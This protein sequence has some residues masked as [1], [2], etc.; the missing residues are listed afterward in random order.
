MQIR[1]S[2]KVHAPVLSLLWTALFLFFLLPLPKASATDFS[3]TNFKV[4]DPVFQAA[5]TTLTSSTNFRLLGTAGEIAIGTSSAT[6]FKVSSGFLYYPEVI[7]LPSV[8]ATAGDKSVDLSWTPASAVLGWKVSGYN[9]GYATVSDGPY[10]YGSNV[11]STTSGTVTG[12]TNGTKYYFIVRPEDA[13]GNII[14]TSSETSATPSAPTVTPAP[15]GG[16]VE[17][18]LKILKFPSDFVS[19]PPKPAECPRADLNCDGIVD[20]ADLSIFLH[21]ADRQEKSVA[22]LNKSG[23]IGLGDI[24]ILFHEWTARPFVAKDILDT[25]EEMVPE[26]GL[27]FTGSRIR[28]EAEFGGAMAEDYAKPLILSVFNSIRSA[29]LKVIGFFSTLWYALVY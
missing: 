25:Q 18:I 24:S 5:T 4:Q 8:T 29:V 16:I 12:L 15:G 19:I 17:S 13:F 7:A 27:A 28:E 9:I 1:L 10:T 11:G 21:F 14:A 23:A 6:S 26:E 22:D 3:S 20:L 2:T